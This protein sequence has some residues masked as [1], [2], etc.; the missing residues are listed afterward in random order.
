M[1][2]ISGDIDTVL[3]FYTYLVI[4]LQK[5]INSLQAQ[6]VIPPTAWPCHCLTNNYLFWTWTDLQD[7]AILAQEG[8]NKLKIS[9]P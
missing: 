7:D 4:Y 3:S 2:L 6:S 1:L 8:A 9:E 5:A